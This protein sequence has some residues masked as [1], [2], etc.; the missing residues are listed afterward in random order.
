MMEAED[1]SEGSK[2]MAEAE[3]LSLIFAL[4]GRCSI[5]RILVSATTPSLA[6]A[7]IRG[8]GVAPTGE[9]APYAWHNRLLRY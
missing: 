7:T 5:L 8:T 3:M 2:V 6:E 4:K 1:L 9:S